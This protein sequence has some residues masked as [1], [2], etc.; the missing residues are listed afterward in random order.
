MHKQEK[1]NE[2]HIRNPGANGSR[3]I[4]IKEKKVNIISIINNVY[5]IYSLTNFH[6]QLNFVNFEIA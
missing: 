3:P 4:D 1:V 6:N 5:C 2:T